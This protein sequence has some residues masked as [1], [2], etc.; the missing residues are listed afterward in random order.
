MPRRRVAVALLP[1]KAI[2]A[3]IQGLRSLLDDPRI[4][5]LPPHLTL[6]PPVNLGEQDLRSLRGALRSVAARSAEFELR[7]GPVSSFAPATPTLHLSV[8]G[9]VAALRE[10]REQLR[11][12]PVDRPET[13][14]F[15]AHVTLRESVALEQIAPALLLLTG[16]LAAWTVDRVYVLEQRP[17]GKLARW[18]PI[19]EEPFGAPV[20]VG[21]GGIELLL[22]TISLLEPQV[23]QLL[24]EHSPLR[25]SELEDQDGQMLVIAE[26]VEHPGRAVGVALGVV[27]GGSAE[28][29]QLLVDPECRL[30]GIARHTLMHWCSEAA[31]RNAKVAVAAF[32]ESAQILQSWGFERV[33]ASMLRQ[34]LIDSSG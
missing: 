29:Q 15:T 23:E 28:L 9:Q 4:T 2:S 19:A 34:L 31:N 6:V 32:S 17:Q 7:L 12:P 25:P 22:R 3:Q 13:W 18:V 21:R 16:E 10:L 8:S 20:V 27:S 26:H 1:P 5:D 30:Q 14:P 24:S 33:G 11:V